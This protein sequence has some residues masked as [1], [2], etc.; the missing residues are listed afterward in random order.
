[1]SSNTYNYNNICLQLDLNT[2]CVSITNKLPITAENKCNEIRGIS[3]LM[4]VCVDLLVCIE[5]YTPQWIACWVGRGG[6][7]QRHHQ[8][9]QKSNESEGP[10]L[11][12][13]SHSRLTDT[14]SVPIS[15]LRSIPVGALDKAFW[16]CD[17]YGLEAKPNQNSLG[18]HDDK[19]G[20]HTTNSLRKVM[21]WTKRQWRELKVNQVWGVDVSGISRIRCT[22]RM[23]V[24]GCR[25]AH[26]SLTDHFKRHRLLTF[27]S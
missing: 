2:S 16:V 13:G 11:H 27:L 9:A 10:E 19:C 12:R 18:G 24:C 8:G 4:Y 14:S 23:M 21:Y 20:S 5:C 7:T 6:G 22:W 15:F 17:T 3:S 25:K 1:M 26:R